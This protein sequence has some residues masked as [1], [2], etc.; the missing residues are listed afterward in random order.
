MAGE[1]TKQISDK[2]VF[3]HSATT[4]CIPNNDRSPEGIVRVFENQ[5][6]RPS[7]ENCFTY[8]QM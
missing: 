1:Y 3:S 2:F 8:E 6:Y 4:N 5:K 7:V